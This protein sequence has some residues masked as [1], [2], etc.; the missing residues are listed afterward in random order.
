MRSVRGLELAT[1]AGLL[2]HQEAA[3]AALR[4]AIHPMTQAFLLPFAPSVERELP[5][6]EML[7]PPFRKHLQV[8]EPSSPRH[9]TLVEAV[10]LR[11]KRAMQELDRSEKD[12]RRKKLVADR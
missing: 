10:R 3:E 11:Y 6:S 7:P 4:A 2:A 9:L 12:Q 5:A 1:S 8:A